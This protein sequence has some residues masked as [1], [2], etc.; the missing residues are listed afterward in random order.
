MSKTT[1]AAIA[2]L[3]VIVVI[4][5]LMYQ[6]SSSVSVSLSVSKIVI[7]FNSPSYAYLNFT[8]HNGGSLPFSGSYT[9]QVSYQTHQLYKNVSVSVG[10][11]QSQSV[12]IVVP[13]NLSISGV[14]VSGQ[15]IYDYSFS[16]DFTDLVLSLQNSFIQG[17]QGLNPPSLKGGYVQQTQVRYPVYYTFSAFLKN[18]TY[19]PNGTKVYTL[20]IE[21]YPLQNGGIAIN[22]TSTIALNTTIAPQM[23]ATLVPG[24][25]ITVPIVTSQSQFRLNFTIYEGNLVVGYGFYNV[26]A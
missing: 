15:G 10:G 8:V 24:K 26:T 17:V 5:A 7:G 20:N 6:T 3:I 16:K 1:I 18:V 4:G 12:I 21:F 25:T 9:V 11:G 13:L 22:G 14:H 23:K 19:Y 2:F